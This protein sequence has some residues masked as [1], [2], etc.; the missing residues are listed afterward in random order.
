MFLLCL[1]PT[2][3]PYKGIHKGGRPPRGP[4][5]FVEEAEGRL[6]YMVDGEVA[7]IAK[8]Y[9]RISKCAL[10]MYIDAYRSEGFALTGYDIPGRMEDGAWMLREN[11]SVAVAAVAA[12]AAAAVAHLLPTTYYLRPTTYDLLPT[13]CYINIAEIAH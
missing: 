3:P 9:R 1:P 13:T 5:P 12:A 7:S 4:P 2:Q 10:N 6:L 8:T 11:S